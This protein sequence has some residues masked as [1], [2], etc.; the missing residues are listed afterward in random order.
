MDGGSESS[1]FFIHSSG[2]DTRRRR[3][4]SR[5]SDDE[6]WAQADQKVPPASPQSVKPLEM[7][8]VHHFPLLP[9]VFTALQSSQVEAINARES[10]RHPCVC[11]ACSCE[12]SE[13]L[14]VGVASIRPDRLPPRHNPASRIRPGLEQRRSFPCVPCAATAL[15]AMMMNRFQVRLCRTCFTEARG[16][17][18]K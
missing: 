3:C 6:L 5:H 10:A 15:A 18:V 14:S 11:S 2:L 17:K 1:F 4:G 16:R 9:H 13:R 7:T 12:M 8:T